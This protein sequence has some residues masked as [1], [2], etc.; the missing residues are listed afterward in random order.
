[1][2]SEISHGSSIILNAIEQTNVAIEVVSLTAQQSAENS[3]GI[4]NNVDDTTKEILEVLK[5]AQQQSELAEELNLLIKKF[6]I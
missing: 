1:M 4:F 6:E 5:L 2:S 3:E